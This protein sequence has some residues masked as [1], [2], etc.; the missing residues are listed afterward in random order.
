[1]SHAAPEKLTLA[2][3]QVG[4]DTHG[5]CRYGRYLAAEGRTRPELAILERSVSLRGPGFDDRRRLREMARELSRADLVHAQ[6]SVWGDGSW[7]PGWRAPANLRTF[8]RHCS[9]HW[10]SPST[11]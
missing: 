3:L 5:I 11:T 4:P 6:V 10:S 2:Y 9:A 7:G 1:M 8:R